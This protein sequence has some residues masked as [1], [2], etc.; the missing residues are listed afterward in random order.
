[1]NRSSSICERNE[2]K[3]LEREIIAETVKCGEM[4]KTL[5]HLRSQ[6]VVP[7]NRVVT[8]Q[9]LLQD[10]EKVKEEK[11]AMHEW[12]ERGVAEAERVSMQLSNLSEEIHRAE[13]R[14]KG[15]NRVVEEMSERYSELQQ[16]LHEEEMQVNSLQHQI[17]TKESD[18][19][20]LG[21]DNANKGDDFSLLEQLTE[22]EKEV[23][24]L[25]CNEAVIETAETSMDCLAA[26]SRRVLHELG[27]ISVAVNS[28][29]LLG[30]LPE[31]NDNG[32]DT[33]SFDSEEGADDT[34]HPQLILTA[35]RAV[36][37][38]CDLCLCTIW[39]GLSRAA[40]DHAH[41]RR[42]QD[43]RFGEAHTAV[44]R[45]LSAT[46][47]DSAEHLQQLRDEVEVWK[48]KY[49]TYERLVEETEAARQYR[50]SVKL[51]GNAYNNDEAADVSEER[52]EAPGSFSA[53]VRHES[54]VLEED[55]Q[56]L[57]AVNESLKKE[58]VTCISDYN[59]LKELKHAYR[60]L[61]VKKLELAHV[62]EKLRKENRAMKLYAW[63][64]DARI[65]LRIIEK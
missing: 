33:E 28:C 29:T 5:K 9:S 36:V 64:T 44:K 35:A 11:R 48:N 8:L 42:Q 6:S 4:E 7:V 1:M 20:E 19:T 32:D 55:H 39:S 56:H 31:K 18:L 12:L 49:R 50:D 41:S 23:N 3:D 30:D 14:E 25:R 47:T 61:E 52:C 10:I 46:G 15:V 63:E 59:A 34:R 21:E 62:N 45:D 38:R 65:S 51:Q 22:V 58:L 57:K 27:K 54:A 53:I 24:K 43:I 40:F 16:R 60:D 2:M 13:V 26:C 37:D 17:A